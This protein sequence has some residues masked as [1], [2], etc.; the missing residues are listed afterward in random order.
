VSGDDGQLLQLFVN[1]LGNALKFRRGRPLI[2][3]TAQ[4][5]GGHWLFAVRDNGIGIAPQY[6]ERIFDMFQR[7]HSRR[8]YTGT[9]MGLA[10]CRRVVHSHGGTIRVVSQPEQ[11]STFFFTL[12]AADTAP[13]A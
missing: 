3:V 9:G 4:R 5:E 2:E 1:L 10:L 8:E 11:G 7:L 13:D 6:F 12:P